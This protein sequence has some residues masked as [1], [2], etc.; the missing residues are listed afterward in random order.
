MRNL[1]L[2]GHSV[3]LFV[4][5]TTIERN[6]VSFRPLVMTPYSFERNSLKRRGQTRKEHAER[7]GGAGG[8]E[9]GKQMGGNGGRGVGLEGGRGAQLR[10]A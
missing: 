8:M 1:A 6:S 7:L 10:V 4:L 2:S 5:F 3:F 9:K